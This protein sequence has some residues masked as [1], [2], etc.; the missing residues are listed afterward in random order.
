[1]KTRFSVF[2][3]AVFLLISSLCGCSTEEGKTII[4]NSSVSN[5][6][7]SFWEGENTLNVITTPSVSYVSTFDDISNHSGDMALPQ[8]YV[9][10]I[11]ELRQGI[12]NYFLNNYQIDLAGR[13]SKQE[14]RLF[15]YENSQNNSATFGYVSNDN[16]DI[17]YLNELL[18]T[19]EYAHLFPNTYIHET[20]HQL[21]ND[22]NKHEAMICE[23]FVEVFTHSILVYMEKPSYPTPLYNTSAQLACQ[24]LLVDN[25]LPHLYF[26]TDDFSFIDRMNERLAGIKQ[27]YDT[28]P[29]KDY[30][31]LY[32]NLLEIL[33]SYADNRPVFS[34]TDPVFYA[35]EAQ[36]L[37]RAYCQTFNPT[38]SIIDIIRAHYIID[39]YENIYFIY[40]N[41]TGLHDIIL[42]KRE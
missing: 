13:L 12:A 7:Y 11:E 42:V 39:C 33:F 32:L 15:S 37:A 4:G 30:G 24:I 8:E 27:E 26:E 16:P 29:V 17:L 28:T 9:P 3:L 38:H 6:N 14:I 20:L 35:Y 21:G 25:E 40:N 1:M 18:L 19:E 10:I 2:L 22:A 36:D 41:V 23:G 31:V 5:G 34:T